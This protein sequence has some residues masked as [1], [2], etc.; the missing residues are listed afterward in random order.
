MDRK[1]SRSSPP[2]NKQTLEQKY[3][4]IFKYFVELG[5][6]RSLRAVAEGWKG[7]AS[8][9]QIA[10]MASRFEWWERAAKHD[11]EVLAKAAEVNRGQL[12][13]QYHLLLDGI[14]A[15]LE[16]TFYRDPATGRVI[17]RLSLESWDD[18]AKAV[19]I[20]D[21]LK[22]DSGRDPKDLSNPQTFSMAVVALLQEIKADGTDP[23]ISTASQAKR[24]IAAP[25]PTSTAA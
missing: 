8:L 18:V 25:E 22:G 21:Y 11:Q 15:T 16:K 1:K 5:P 14:D 24:W 19:R 13:A 7:L 23:F 10:E 20:R 17:S 2:R 4:A 12:D 3:D 9:R 6:N